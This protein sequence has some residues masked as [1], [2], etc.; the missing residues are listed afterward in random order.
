MNVLIDLSAV[1]TGGGLQLAMNYIL[2]NKGYSKISFHLVVNEALKCNENIKKLDNIIGFCP[3]SVVN[4]FFFEY[5]V[6]PRLIKKFNISKIFT[7]FGS[8][9][10]RTLTA[11]KIVGVA[12]PIIC[13]P[14]SP[15]WNNIPSS[16]R[17]K[18]N[19]WNNIRVSRLKK[20]DVI[21]AETE[22]MKN[23]LSK[24]FSN[25]LQE[26]IVF[27]PTVSGFVDDTDVVFKTNSIFT[28]LVLG[29]LA[30]HKNNW[31]LYSIA[32]I[33]KDKKIKFKFL[34][35][36]NRDEFV[37]HNYSMEN[38]DIDPLILDQ[39]F[40]FVGTRNPNEINYLYERSNAL[41]NIS[42]LESYSNNYMES[43]K[44]SVLL[45]CSDRDFSRAICRQSAIYCDPHSAISV[46]N[47]IIKASNLNEE[48]FK[49]YLHKGKQY[50]SE[51]PSI[52]SKNNFINS[53]LLSK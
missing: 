18:K 24:L 36:F 15:Y 45:I 25:P 51:L 22:V 46:A 42:D 23:R 5:F 49:Y 33:L 47:S 39:Y 40:E 19:I 4:R 20:A 9:L 34:C 28:I 52:E 16:E 48:D 21:I 1:R 30:Y 41:I 44:A 13:Y 11:K 29:G 17:I 53:L 43:W 8:G 31:R 12:Y 35:S 26:I 10:P 37:S 38:R 6:I 3:T 7:F 14:D 27:P 2:S 50:L 32:C